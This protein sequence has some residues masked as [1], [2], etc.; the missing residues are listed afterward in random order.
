MSDNVLLRVLRSNSFRNGL[1]AVLCSAVLSV[2]ALASGAVNLSA[3]NYTDVFCGSALPPARFVRPPTK[4]PVIVDVSIFNSAFDP[5]NLTINAGDTVRWTNNDGRIHTSTSDSAV[6]IR[7]LSVSAKH[8]ALR[9]TVRVR[10]VITAAFTQLCWARSRSN[11]PGRAWHH[12]KC[13]CSPRS[14]DQCRRHR[15]MD[16]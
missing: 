9:S 6:W 10:S 1:L 16:K 3:L 12:R 13:I 15:H 8:S 4:G 14:G 2:A 5:A 11:L 7:E